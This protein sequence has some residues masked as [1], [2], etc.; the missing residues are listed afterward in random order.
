MREITG[1]AAAARL[2]GAAVQSAVGIAGD[3]AGWPIGSG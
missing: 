2:T 1:S 3:D